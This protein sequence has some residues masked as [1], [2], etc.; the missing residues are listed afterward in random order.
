MTVLGF[1]ALLV[2]YFGAMFTVQWYMRRAEAKKQTV[3]ADEEC[4]EIRRVT[5]FCLVASVAFGER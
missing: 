3:Q 4:G 5:R 2:V 1:I